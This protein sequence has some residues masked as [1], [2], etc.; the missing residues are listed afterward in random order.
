[1]NIFGFLL[2]FLYFCIP[3]MKYE[4]QVIFKELD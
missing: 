2:I 4:K 1:M 3:F